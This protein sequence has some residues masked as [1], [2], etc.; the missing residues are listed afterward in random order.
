MRKKK[1]MMIHH[2]GLIGGGSISFY[3]IYM[4]LKKKYDVVLYITDDPPDLLNFLRERGIEPRTF[5]FKLGKL[6]YYSG[7]NNL[8][9]PRFWYHAFRILF[10]IKYWKDVIKKENPEMV[11]VNSKVLC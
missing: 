11:I 7:G 2:S 5:S 10:Q 3:N 9:K 1:V 4:E 6:T 8:L